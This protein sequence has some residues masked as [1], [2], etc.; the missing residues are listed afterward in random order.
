MLTTSAKSVPRMA[1][2]ATTVPSQTRMEADF[3]NFLQ[4]QDDT[5]VCEDEARR[6]LTAA[7]WTWRFVYTF[8]DGAPVTVTAS[9]DR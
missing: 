8:T 4:K 6:A 2:V 1:P 5:F 7:G 9:C 3:K